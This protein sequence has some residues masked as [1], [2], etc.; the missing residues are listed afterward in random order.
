MANRPPLDTLPDI[1]RPRIDHKPPK[2]FFGV[3]VTSGYVVEYARRRHLK[4]YLEEDDAEYALF[5]GK[6]VLDMA[7]LDDDALRDPNTRSTVITASRQLTLNDLTA[8]CQSPHLIYGHPFCRLWHSMVALWTNYTFEQFDHPYL[9]LERLTSTLL[10]ALDVVEG[11]GDKV[12]WWFEWQ[13][14]VVRLILLSRGLQGSHASTYPIRD[15]TLRLDPSS[16]NRYQS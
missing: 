16:A 12:Q 7:D 15:S 5:G 4:L 9:D 11:H 6:K 13:N 14:N 1:L 2:Y 3:P 10:S 8:R